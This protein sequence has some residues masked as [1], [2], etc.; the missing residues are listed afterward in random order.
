MH[1]IIEPFMEMKQCK[2]LKKGLLK[3]FRGLHVWF[4]FDAHLFNLLNLILLEL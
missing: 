1:S 2:T 3:L 4:M